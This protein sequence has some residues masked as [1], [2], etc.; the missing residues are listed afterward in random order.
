MKN[1][2]KYSKT[3]DIRIKLSKIVFII[4]KISYINLNIYNIYI[5][6]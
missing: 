3:N 6:L 4:Y 5:N 1:N 2:C